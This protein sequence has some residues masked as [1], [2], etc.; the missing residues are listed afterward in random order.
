[1]HCAMDL[2]LKIRSES[3]VTAQDVR[4]TETFLSHDCIYKDIDTVDKD[5]FRVDS[6]KDYPIPYETYKTG[7]KTSH[8]KKNF[9]KQFLKKIEEEKNE[10][11]R[12][13]NTE[14]KELQKYV[15]GTSKSYRH[16]DE[17]ICSTPNTP[18]APIK[19]SYSNEI[20]RRIDAALDISAASY[21]Q[22]H[23]KKP[24]AV[25]TPE[26]MKNEKKT[27]L[28]SHSS[29]KNQEKIMDTKDT[30]IITGKRR[31]HFLVIKTVRPQFSHSS[32][33]M[34]E[35]WPKYRFLGI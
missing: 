31:C 23:L 6:G 18:K 5:K 10:V 15:S 2:S 8:D 27:R 13:K 19:R 7:R 32:S 4:E 21:P 14:Y 29:A 25:D 17:Y 1:M 22:G 16:K 26:E 20:C 28:R 30:R 3:R 9:Q 34:D 11:K 12:Q 35:L 33:K 24:F